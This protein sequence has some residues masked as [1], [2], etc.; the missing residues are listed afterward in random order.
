LTWKLS[1]TKSNRLLFQ[2]A[3]S[4]PR[5][6][7]I[8]YGLLP[9]SRANKHTPQSREDFTPNLAYRIQMLPT[10]R[11]QDNGQNRHFP[12]RG[13]SLGATIAP[14]AGQKTGLKLQPAFALWMMGYPTDWCDLEDGEMP[15]S[16]R[17]GTR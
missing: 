13:K 1:A 6:G 14:V 12:E 15:P 7:E 3:P 10:P 8:E 17:Q 16:K 4:M 2:L 11:A 5:I 9:T